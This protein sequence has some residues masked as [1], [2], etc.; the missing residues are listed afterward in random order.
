MAI[1]SCIQR[2]LKSPLGQRRFPEGFEDPTW[3]EEQRMLLGF[4]RFMYWNQLKTDMKRGLLRW[5]RLDLAKLERWLPYED[6]PAV[7]GKQAYTA[8]F[9][10]EDLIA[11]GA[12]KRKLPALHIKSFELLELPKEKEF[13]WKCQPAPSSLAITQHWQPG[14]KFHEL[15]APEVIQKIARLYS[16]EH[17]EL[18]DL[19]HVSC[20]RGYCNGSSSVKDEGYSSDSSSGSNSGGDINPQTGER[21]RIRSPHGSTLRYP[22]SEEDTEIQYWSVLTRHFHDWNP[23]P[24]RDFDSELKERDE[25]FDLGRPPLGLRFWRSMSL[26]P[27][28]G[29]A[30]YMWFEGYIRY[31]FA[32]WEEK[33]MIDLGL[34]SNGII[35]DM[36]EYYQ[37]WYQ[38]LH[39]EDIS[40][41]KVKSRFLRSEDE[42]MNE[43]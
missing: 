9:Y 12:P 23:R 24:V 8:L 42:L 25:W 41:Y 26:D 43:A 15:T 21:L 35:D 30:K 38:F 13:G 2:C 27:E 34:W 4:W 3:T 5:T 14:E 28:G 7:F 11:P 6:S 39:P 16:A 18:S 33:R 31:G 17:D 19:T 20:P 10:I 37:R 40:R 22:T 29:P 32:L 1:E 36:S